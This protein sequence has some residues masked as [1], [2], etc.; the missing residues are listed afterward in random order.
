VI[1]YLIL[2]LLAIGLQVSD[3]CRQAAHLISL[4][5]APGQA[6]AVTASPTLTPKPAPAPQSLDEEPLTLDEPLLLLDDPSTLS[7]LLASAEGPVADNSRCFV[8]HTNYQTEELVL[9]HAL[10]EVG[11]ETCH[12]ASNAHCSDEENVTSPDILFAKEDVR[13]AC[14]TCHLQPEATQ[15]RPLADKC[16]EAQL[17]TA[18]HGAHR[19]PVRTRHWDA[20]T[21]KLLF[22][23]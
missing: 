8:C 11:C 17:C 13:E 5:S 18:C 7:A 10:H 20:R 3:A 16:D 22:R 19:M 14:L 15:K 2:V 21:G 23:S 6:A 12:G 9:R 4:W 1:K